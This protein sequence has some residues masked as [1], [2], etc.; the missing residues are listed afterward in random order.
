MPPVIV[1][2]E[3]A[4]AELQEAQ[5]KADA[6]Y[7]L[8]GT[9][10]P[11]AVHGEAPLD[12]RRRLAS[13][14]QKHSKDWG[15]QSLAAVSRDVLAPI[16]TAIY[17]DAA[18]EARNPQNVPRGQLREIRTPDGSGRVVSEFVGHPDDAFA[19]FKVPAQRCKI[20]RNGHGG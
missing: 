8:H 11:M 14:L 4:R 10:A 12:Y 15:K 1:Q 18:A 3:A 13:G 17:A 9:T 20:S 16:E 5:A 7:R 6:V 2:T 19:P